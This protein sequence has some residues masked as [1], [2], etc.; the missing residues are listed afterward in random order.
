[1]KLACLI[2]GYNNPVSIKVKDLASLNFNFLECDYEWWCMQP[3]PHIDYRIT[4][5]G[6]RS[7]WSS[8]LQRQNNK[9]SFLTTWLLLLLLPFFSF[10]QFPPLQVGHLLSKILNC[11]R[12]FIQIVKSPTSDMVWQCVYKWGQSSP[13]K[14]VLWCCVRPNHDF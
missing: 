3:Q 14:P 11:P 1:M 6:K 12:F 13:H 4:W 5:N 7:M 9:S 8:F 10:L 2:S